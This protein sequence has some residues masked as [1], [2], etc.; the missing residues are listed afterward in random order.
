MGQPIDTVTDKAAA[1]ATEVKSCSQSLMTGA[2]LL[3]SQLFFHPAGCPT[4]LAPPE[5]PPVLED[6][7]PC[8]FLLFSRD[9][10][11]TPCSRSPVLPAVVSG[12]ISEAPEARKTVK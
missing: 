6:L 2:L 5:T 9:L 11:V 10:Y 8:L 3:V 1:T 4:T 7:F 12:G